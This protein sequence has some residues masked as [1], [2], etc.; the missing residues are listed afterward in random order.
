MQDDQTIAFEVVK[1]LCSHATMSFITN[2]EHQFPNQDL[3]NAIDIVY[4]QYWLNFQSLFNEWVKILALLDE[5]KLDLATSLFKIT[6][7]N[8]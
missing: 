7:Q 8:N 2:F 1:V 3:M 4:P 6:M 5:L